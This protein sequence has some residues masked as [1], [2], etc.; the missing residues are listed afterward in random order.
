MP[1]ITLTVLVVDGDALHARAIRDALAHD[2]HDVVVEPDPARAAEVATRHALDA[3]IVDVDLPDRSG[4]KLARALRRHHLEHAAVVVGVSAEGITV[5]AP[6]H[7]LAI[8]VHLR[9]PIET[10][11]LS[12]LL[13]YLRTHRRRG[14]TG[15]GER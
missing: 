9:R 1:Q 2:G 11:F 4:Y 8:D 14:E 12:G 6:E 10:Q 5:E 15:P 3:V 7:A 13:H